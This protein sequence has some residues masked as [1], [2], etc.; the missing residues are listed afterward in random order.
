MF[1]LNLRGLGEIR[2]I[3]CTI[4]YIS[5]FFIGYIIACKFVY[6]LECFV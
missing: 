5:C 2:F 4:I 1:P 3:Q 6:L